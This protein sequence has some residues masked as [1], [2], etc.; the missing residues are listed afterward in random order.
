MSLAHLSLCES[1]SV[2]FGVTIVGENGLKRPWSRSVNVVMRACCTENLT[3]RLRTRT[4]IPVEE[5]GE[6]KDGLQFFL[7][8]VVWVLMA[9]IE[10]WEMGMNTESLDLREK[11]QKWLKGDKT[12][13]NDLGRSMAS[14]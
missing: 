12:S 9:S 11:K 6:L 4:S 14:K 1:K 3:P 13:I 8:A 5:E 7:E 10:E 2:L